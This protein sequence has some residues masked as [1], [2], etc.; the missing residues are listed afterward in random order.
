[1]RHKILGQKEPS[2]CPHAVLLVYIYI[3]IYILIFDRTEC[4]CNSSYISIWE[5]SSVLPNPEDI[6][7]N[8][9]L[10]KLKLRNSFIVSN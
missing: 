9:V 8:D 3:H 5:I 7:N 1:M 10:G 6:I 4:V 2:Q